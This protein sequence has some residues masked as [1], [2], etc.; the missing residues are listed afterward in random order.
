MILPPFIND[1]FEFLKPSKLSPAD[2]RRVSRKTK[3]IVGVSIDH[4]SKHIGS[5]KGVS[6]KGKQ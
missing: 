5:F 2:F 1:L 3:N 4:N 6:R